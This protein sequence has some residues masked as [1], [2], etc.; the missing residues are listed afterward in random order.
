MSVGQIR[1]RPVGP[2]FQAGW[3]R[4]HEFRR[5]GESRP[6]HTSAR[7]A[8]LLAAACLAVLLPL[9]AAAGAE[10][11]LIIDLRTG[12]LIAA[13]V[14]I[15]ADLV[16]AFQRGRRIT[17]ASG[18]EPDQAKKQTGSRNRLSVE[19]VAVGGV[20][21]DIPGIAIMVLRHD[22]AL[23]KR[24]QVRNLLGR[25]GKLHLEPRGAQNPFR[26]H[27][28]ARFMNSPPKVERGQF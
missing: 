5:I 6:G 17:C 15:C 1:S 14:S 28:V 13:P 25:V 16:A 22:L 20:R 27:R 23:R 9:T 4:L 2:G 19:A 12:L 7:G 21:V 3:N 24:F 18:R 11:V 10:A 26:V 8:K